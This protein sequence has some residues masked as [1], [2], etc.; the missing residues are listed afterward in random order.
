MEMS[1]IHININENTI[2]SNIYLTF[3]QKSAMFYCHVDKMFLFNFSGVHVTKY[4]KRVQPYWLIKN[5]WGP[6]WGERGYYKLYRG[7]GTCGINQ[8]ATS[9]VVE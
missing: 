5:S 3:N 1:A 7:D 2:S 6:G 8:M 9:A 4:L